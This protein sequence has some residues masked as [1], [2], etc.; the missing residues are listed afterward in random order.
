MLDRPRRSTLLIALFA[1]A[2]L[3]GTPAAGLTICLQADGGI[4]IGLGVG[5]GCPCDEPHDG[6][7]ESRDQD[8]GEPHAPCIDVALDGLRDRVDLDAPRLDAGP[9]TALLIALATPSGACRR[10]CPASPAP[11]PPDRFAARAAESRAKTRAQAT[12]VVTVLVI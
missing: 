11:R 9:G 5:L 8:G 2:I 1:C 12:R 3:V 6:R 10:P 4:E 7:D